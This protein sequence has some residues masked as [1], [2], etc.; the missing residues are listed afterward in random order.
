MKN[1][2]PTL[3]YLNERLYLDG[4]ARSRFVLLRSI[5]WRESTLKRRVI[6]RKELEKQ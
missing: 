5:A 4:C 6:D 3:E 2:E 1:D